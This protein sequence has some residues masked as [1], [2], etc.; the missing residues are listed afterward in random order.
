MRIAEPT[1]ILELIEPPKGYAF[2]AG[3]WLTHDLDWSALCNLV[4]P[5]LTN[6]TTTGDRR[7]HDVRAGVDA[8]APGLVVLHAGGKHFSGGPALPWACEIPVP[9]RRQHA[10]AALLVYRSPSGKKARTKAFVASA[11]LTSS[12]LTSNLE[13]VTWDERGSSSTP[14]I[15]VDLFR[16]IVALTR[17][18]PG[19]YLAARPMQAVRAA[20]R[21]IE[22]ARVLASSLLS[23]T[24]MVPKRRRGEPPAASITIVSPSFAGN[25]DTRAGAALAPWCGEDTVVHIYAPFSGTREGARSGERSLELSNGLLTTLKKTGASVKV[26]AVPAQEDGADVGRR[27]HAKLLAIHRA[28]GTVSVLTGSANC[29]GPGLEGRN[30]EVMV[31]QLRS[32]RQLAAMVDSLD[33]VPFA[34]PLAAPPRKVLAPSILPAPLVSASFEIDPGARADG[35]RWSGTL[36][37]T[38]EDGDEQAMVFYNGQRVDLGKPTTLSF[39]PAVGTIEV[40][41]GG[42]SIFTQVHVEPPPAVEDFWHRL[43]P[44]RSVDRP[45]HDLLRLLRDVERPAKP[46]RPVEDGTVKAGKQPATDGFSIPL[47]QRLV[48]IA[49]LRRSLADRSHPAMTRF[50]DDYL[51]A[52]TAAEVKGGVRAEEVAA[53]RATALAIHAAYDPQAPAQRDPLLRS[54]TDAIPSFDRLDA[55]AGGGS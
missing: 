20:L 14:F 16:E 7:M 11:N 8:D 38:I 27:L 39:D 45:D 5:A 26:H 34:G 36:T 32:P 49:R 6:V 53:A 2:H 18:I 55:S 22:P 1:S 46:R 17:T 9:G 50:L 29:T 28:N 43:T 15:G 47:G 12:G 41:V 35:S 33:A 4:A 30:R 13:V 51:D 24:S 54:L 44:E 37:V 40:R 19:G 42:R 23:E 21:G 31:R 52:R 48:I 25:T 10:K 3:I